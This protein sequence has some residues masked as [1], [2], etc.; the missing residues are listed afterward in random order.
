M[1]IKSVKAGADFLCQLETDNIAA[2]NFSIKD[3]LASCFEM[4]KCNFSCN[5]VQLIQRKIIHQSRPGL[6]PAVIW[7]INR[8]N[9]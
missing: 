1:P 8:I 2:L 9:T 6:N 3:I 4:F 7:L 5:A